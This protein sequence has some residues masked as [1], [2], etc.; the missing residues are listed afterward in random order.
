MQR[1]IIGRRIE[2]AL[3]QY[4]A[5]RI[6]REL[7]GVAVYRELRIAGAPVLGLAFPG[8][9]WIAVALGHR[10]LAYLGFPH[11]DAFVHALRRGYVDAHE[12]LLGA[13]PDPRF[14]GEFEDEVEPNAA[15]IGEW[16]ALP[17][18]E[19]PTAFVIGSGNMAWH[20][21]ETGLAQSGQRLGFGV[22]DVAAAGVASHSFT[23]MFGEAWAYRGIEIDN[24][25]RMASPDLLNALLTGEETQTV[26]RFRPTLMPAPTLR[27]LEHGVT[28]VNTSPTNPPNGGPRA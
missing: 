23:L 14:F 19:R 12:R 10:K 20:A 9:H 3:A 25:A 7:E 1:E 15:R 2:C 6:G 21:L 26:F 4:P 28:F 13:S 18:C 16:L 24:L 17:E 27:L 8:R 11:D 5:E 22:K